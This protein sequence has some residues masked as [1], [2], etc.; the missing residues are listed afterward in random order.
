MQIGIA[1]SSKHD[2][3]A[4]SVLIGRWKHCIREYKPFWAKILYNKGFSGRGNVSNGHIFNVPSHNF[5][6]FFRQGDDI[7][8]LTEDKATL[9]NQSCIQVKNNCGVLGTH[10][11]RREN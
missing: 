6:H 10:V 2:W 5:P 1:S 3:P 8:Y 4:P 7:W 11:K 9:V